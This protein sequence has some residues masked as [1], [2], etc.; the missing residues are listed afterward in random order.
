M[1]DMWLELEHELRRCAYFTADMMMPPLETNDGEE[2]EW[3]RL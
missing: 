2:Q 1:W 3:D